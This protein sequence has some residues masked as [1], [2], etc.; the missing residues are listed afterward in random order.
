MPHLTLLPAVPAPISSN[1]DVCTV[2][3][4]LLGDVPSA[5]AMYVCAPQTRA[6]TRP[7]RP[8]L[9][10]S[11]RPPPWQRAE[12]QSP[13]RSG[14]EDLC[15][16]QHA[17]D[18]VRAAMLAAGV[19]FSCLPRVHGPPDSM[20]RPAP[21]QHQQIAQQQRADAPRCQSLS[22]QNIHRAAVSAVGA[23]PPPRATPWTHRGAQVQPA[24][25]LRATGGWRTTGSRHSQRLFSRA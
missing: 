6:Q 18:C 16:P 24:S 5:Q 20:A 4:D 2:P 10:P 12:L 8:V 23:S 13:E 1:E 7:R 19:D 11:V 21:Q 25:P 3:P 17:Q 9:I 22:Q 14:S 15:P